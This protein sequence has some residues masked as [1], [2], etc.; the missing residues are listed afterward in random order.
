MEACDVLLALPKEQGIAPLMQTLPS[1]DAE[2]RATLIHAVG[3]SHAQSAVPTLAKEVS[4]PDIRVSAAALLALSQIQG[5]DAAEA[6]LHLNPTTNNA[7][8]IIEARLANATLQKTNAPKKAKALFESVYNDA[9]APSYY[10]AAALLGLAS[11]SPKELTATVMD[12]LKDKDARLRYA[13]VSALYL[14]EPAACEDLRKLFPALPKETQLTILPLWAKRQIRTAEPEVIAC[15]TAADSD[16][17]LSAIVAL[18]KIGSAAAIPALLSVAAGGG[19]LAKE[20]EST[21]QQIPGEA[22]VKALRQASQESAAAQSTLAVKV[23]AARMDPGSIPF[24]LDVAAGADTKKSEIALTAVKNQAGADALTRLRK[25]LQEKP[26]LKENLSQAVIAICKRQQHPRTHLSEF[27]DT[28]I[29]AEI[30][31]QIKMLSMINLANGKRVTASHPC[32]GNLTPELAIDNNPETYWSCAFSPS[33]IQVDLGTPAPVSRIKVVNYVDGTR[34]YQYRV[35]ISADEKQWVCVGDMSQNTA[36]ATKEGVTHDFKE[37]N[38]RFVRI[39]ML[40]N[41]ANPGMHISELG[42]YGVAP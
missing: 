30:E 2:R 8:R 25:L 28:P 3:L 20:A 5:S 23:L 27:L 17:N 16:L 26:E 22:T 12:A 24:L 7:F 4:A 6:L 14:L 29:K 1:L 31:Q 13:A 40:K 19:P 42:I 18:R 36:P 41:S 21:L 32:Q 33:W 39:T 15:L 9:T 10:R 35:E 34:Y 37:V 38:A 11:L